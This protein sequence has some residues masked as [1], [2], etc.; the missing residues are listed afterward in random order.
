M[1]C[2]ELKATDRRW[3]G[4]VGNSSGSAMI[5]EGKEMKKMLVGHATLSAVFGALAVKHW[6]PHK[7]L[8]HCMQHYLRPQPGR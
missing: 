8:W 5:E 1:R 3:T 4:K 7:L 6:P 2:K